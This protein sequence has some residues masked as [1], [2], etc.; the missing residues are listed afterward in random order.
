MGGSN[1]EERKGRVNERE[2]GRGRGEEIEGKKR[3]DRGVWVSWR[4]K[5]GRHIGEIK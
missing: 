1:G 3:G 4:D 5:Q 2:D